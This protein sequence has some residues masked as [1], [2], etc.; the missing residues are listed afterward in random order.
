ML[1]QDVQWHGRL[2]VQ[3][4]CP[5][6]TFF[7]AAFAPGGLAFLKIQTLAQGRSGAEKVSLSYDFLQGSELTSAVSLSI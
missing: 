1:A 7:F 3:A 2:S 4:G 6:L 5:R